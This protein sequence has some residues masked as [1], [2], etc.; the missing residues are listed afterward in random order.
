MSAARRRNTL[1]VSR[2]GNGDNWGD[3]PSQEEAVLVFKDVNRSERD[4]QSWI[5]VLAKARVGSR[6]S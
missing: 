2:D 5:G 6:G 3:G 4:P 1:Y